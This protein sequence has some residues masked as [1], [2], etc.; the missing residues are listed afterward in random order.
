MLMLVTLAIELALAALKLDNVPAKF[1]RSVGVLG[2]GARR[3]WSPKQGVFAS[4]RTQRA[5]IGKLPFFAFAAPK[6]E[7]VTGSW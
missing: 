5:R 7:F 6:L 3:S 1:F 4:V 2:W